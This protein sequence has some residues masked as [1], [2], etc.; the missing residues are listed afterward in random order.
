[1]SVFSPFYLKMQI[2][3]D[4]NNSLASE[5]VVVWCDLGS[6]LRVMNGFIVKICFSLKSEIFSRHCPES[7]FPQNSPGNF[8]LYFR[9]PRGLPL[10]FALLA[11]SV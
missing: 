4:N 5:V 8:Y 7:H 11:R 1:M 3:Q 10:D 6:H 9:K 2:S